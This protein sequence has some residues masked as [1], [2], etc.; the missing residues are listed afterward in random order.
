MTLV[1]S[2]DVGAAFA[3]L[4]AAFT[5]SVYNRLP[6]SYIAAPPFT[7]DHFT[8]PLTPSMSDMISTR[9]RLYH[10]KSA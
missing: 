10:R 9:I 4:T 1:M 5:S 7:C 6:S 2:I 3:P 8:I